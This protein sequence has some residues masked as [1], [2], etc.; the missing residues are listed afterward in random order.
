MEQDEII[1]EIEDRARALAVHIREICLAAGVHPT[2][3]SRWK[4][5]GKRER[6]RSV[7]GLDKVSQLLRELDRREA[8]RRPP[9][10]KQKR[11]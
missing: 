7:A 1:A 3:F 9:D 11:G 4:Q 2:T 10:R 8:E 6:T 5:S